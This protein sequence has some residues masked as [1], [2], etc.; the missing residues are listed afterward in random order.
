MLIKFCF[1]NISGRDN[2][3][4]L[5]FR[6]DYLLI[7]QLKNILTSFRS[8]HSNTD[9][10]FFG[11]WLAKKKIWYVRQDLWLSLKD[12]LTSLDH[13]FVPMTPS[14]SKRYIEPQPQHTHSNSHHQDHTDQQKNSKRNN[15]SKSNKE[16]NNQE[17]DKDDSSYRQ[18]GIKSKRAKTYAKKLSYYNQ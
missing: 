7:R 12:E 16:Y 1:G 9:P 15:K 8:L 11:G 14:E 13:I 5:T 2:E 18:R 6:F 17:S 3:V 4:A 10:W